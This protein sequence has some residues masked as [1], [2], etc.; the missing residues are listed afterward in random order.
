MLSKQI[1]LK[2]LIKKT[3]DTC[4]SRTYAVDSSSE[5]DSVDH[6]NEDDEMESLSS[7]E[8]HEPPPHSMSVTSLFSEC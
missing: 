5:D 1:A 4:F 2:K 3:S 7:S 8:D 6:E